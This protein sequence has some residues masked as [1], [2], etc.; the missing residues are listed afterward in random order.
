M[1]KDENKS[2]K[3]EQMFWGAQSINKI[4]GLKCKKR[5]MFNMFASLTIRK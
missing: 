2:Y 4:Y 1:N 5:K 3:Y